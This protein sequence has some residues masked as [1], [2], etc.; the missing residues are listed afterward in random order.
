VGTPSVVVDPTSRPGGMACN[1]YA[2][3]AR[4]QCC[5]GRCSP[6]LTRASSP[7][8]T[9]AAPGRRGAAATEAAAALIDCL[10]LDRWRLRA[11]LFLI[12][13]KCHHAQSGVLVGHCKEGLC[14]TQPGRDVSFPSRLLDLADPGRSARSGPYFL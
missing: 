11:P 2:M 9:G 6:P 4:F 12:S 10:D 1:A 14:D 13:F 8:L 3:N 7:P 5:D